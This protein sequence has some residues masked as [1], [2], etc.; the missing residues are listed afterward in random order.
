[1]RLAASGTYVMTTFAIFDANLIRFEPERLD[2][3]EIDLP[4][5]V[6]DRDARVNVL[7]D[8]IPIR[9]GDHEDKILGDHNGVVDGV[10][11]AFGV[12]GFYC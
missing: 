6:R 11:S 3:Q 2:V 7:D 5:C 12:I 9:I 4:V 10:A 8:D 1:M